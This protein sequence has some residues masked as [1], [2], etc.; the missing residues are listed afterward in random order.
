M[1]EKKLTRRGFLAGTLGGSVGVIIAYF[2]AKYEWLRQRSV[3][4]VRPTV[5]GPGPFFTAHEFR[6]LSLLTAHIVPDEE[7]IPGAGALQ[8]ATTIEQRIHGHQSMERRYRQGLRWLDQAAARTFG[9]G[10]RFLDLTTQQQ[11]AL[12]KQADAELSRRLDPAVNVM[13]RAWRKYDI[14]YNDLFGLGSG[15]T[16]FALARDD[17]FEA[18]YGD[19]RS[20]PALGYD[21]PP[22]PRGYWDGAGGKW[23]IID[24]CP[25]QK[26]SD[27]PFRPVE[28]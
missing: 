24:H 7:N 5:A 13:E 9:R 16:F 3:G 26:R 19:P 23:N 20:W 21:G 28:G 4:I 12:L 25:P 27:F 11:E 17:T 10:K 2:A 22:Q 8:A 6:T 15:V 14:L 1:K 18:V